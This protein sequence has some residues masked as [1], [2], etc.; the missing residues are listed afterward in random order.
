MKTL[1]NCYLIL[2]GFAILFALA[3]R[4]IPGVTITDLVLGFCY[5]LGVMALLAGIVTAA[6][7]AFY[8]KEKKEDTEKEDSTTIN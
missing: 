1:R 6:I 2:G 4:F 3:A 8:R 5:G 7:P